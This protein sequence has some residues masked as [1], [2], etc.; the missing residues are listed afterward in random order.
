ML[1]IYGEK[2][3]TVPKAIV[4][5]SFKKESKN[6]GV[7]ELVEV[8]GHGHA[9]TIDSGWKQVAQTALDFIKKHT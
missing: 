3:N 6:P 4:R 5:A 2:D 9:I 1:L 8:K 7:T